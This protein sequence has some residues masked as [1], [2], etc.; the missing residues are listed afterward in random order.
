MKRILIL[1]LCVLILVMCVS[2]CGGGFTEARRCAN[3]RRACTEGT[4][5]FVS[6]TGREIFYCRV[7][8]TTCSRCGERATENRTNLLGR[9]RFFCRDCV[10]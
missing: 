9:L 10:S 3:E 7:C 1:I 2:A 6:E 5:R 4:R 8:V